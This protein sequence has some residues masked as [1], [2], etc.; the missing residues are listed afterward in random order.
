MKISFNE[1]SDI[2]EKYKPDN[3][4]FSEEPEYINKIKNIVEYK[5][6][7]PE[8]RILILYA[9]LG[10][11]RAV[12]KVFNVSSTTIQKIIHKIRTKVYD[13]L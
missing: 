13:N 10:N 9:E 11:L 1:L 4:I 12:A 7:E 5:L 6:S 3:D 8:R 2:L